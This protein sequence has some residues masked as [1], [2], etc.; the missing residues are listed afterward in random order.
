MPRQSW[1]KWKQ[2]ADGLTP[3][4]KLI[5]L[6][7]ERMTALSIWVS[8]AVPAESAAAMPVAGNFVVGYFV[9]NSAPVV[10]GGAGNR[11]IVKGWKRLTTGGAHVLNV[12]WVEC[13]TLTGT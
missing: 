4:P 5:R 1:P 12:D 6:L 3:L 10:L 8:S 9:E 7:N 2:I 13:R 11:Y